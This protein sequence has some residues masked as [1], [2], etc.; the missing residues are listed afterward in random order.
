[1]AN[2]DEVI[3]Q[4]I[5]QSWANPWLDVLFTWF[6]DKPTFAYPVIIFFS[7]YLGLRFGKNGWKLAAVFI[8]L[9]VVSDQLSHL[10]K[11]LFQQPRP[12]F[13]LY[14]TLRIPGVEDVRCQSSTSGMPSA[15]T[16]NY[17]A[18]AVFLSWIIR[19]RNLTI[20]LFVLALCVGLSRIYL[21]VHYPGQVLAGAFIGS[22][23]GALMAW[24]GMKYVRF[25]S[26]FHD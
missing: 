9:L 10:L 11:M 4:W 25:L 6:S 16:M 1:M 20:I 14:D 19:E 3:L 21:G 5:N 17:F 23:L 13:L 2:L 26:R 12:C 22:A 7:V 15:H 8:V 24:L 18:A